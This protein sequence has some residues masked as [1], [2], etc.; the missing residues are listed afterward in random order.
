MSCLINLFAFPLLFYLI[1]F[2]GKYAIMRRKFY[3]IYRREDVQ[4]ENNEA[5]QVQ[6]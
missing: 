6:H 3:Q 1:F 5:V 4:K 2:A